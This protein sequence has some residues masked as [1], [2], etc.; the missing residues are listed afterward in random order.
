MSPLAS[1]SP[2]SKY[3]GT[4][5]RLVIG[6]QVA[7]FALMASSAWARLAKPHLASGTI[8][9]VDPDTQ[10]LIFKEAKD[11]K[12]LLLNWNNKTEFDQDGR[13]ASAD[14]LQP[15]SSVKIE[16]RDVSFHSPLLIKVSWETDGASTRGRDG[17]SYFPSRCS[18]S[19]ACLGTSKPL[20]SNP[21]I[22]TIYHSVLLVVSQS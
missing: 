15:G 17:S 8:L 9:A 11:K 19:K 18:F 6:L 22:S 3:H 5:R 2:L 1:P 12:P 4:K 7:L 21:P 14:V 10:T 20:P 13:R 16:F